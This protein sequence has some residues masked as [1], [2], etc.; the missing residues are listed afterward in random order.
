MNF[1]QLLVSTAC[2]EMTFAFL[3][4]VSQIKKKK[5][6]KTAWKHMQVAHILSQRALL[7]SHGVTA[8]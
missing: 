6:E 4:R 5:K 3:A 2:D 7:H 8:K 1:R